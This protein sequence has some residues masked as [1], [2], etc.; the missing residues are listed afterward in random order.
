[1]RQGPEVFNNPGAQ[2]EP[3]KPTPVIN[4]VA[5]AAPEI[6]FQ[7]GHENTR[8]THAHLINERMPGMTI[9]NLDWDHTVT[10]KPP[11]R[12]SFSMELDVA[13]YLDGNGESVELENIDLILIGALQSGRI[14]NI[15]TGKG[16]NAEV[17]AHYLQTRTHELIDKLALTNKFAD[18]RPKTPDG[19]PVIITFT[20]GNGG[21]G[22]D[23][24]SGK[25][26]IHKPI[27]LHS[28]E[29]LLPWS[30][31]LRASTHH[32]R[33]EQIQHKE[34]LIDDGVTVTHPILPPRI[35]YDPMKDEYVLAILHG[36]QVPNTNQ[37]HDHKNDGPITTEEQLYREV[38]PELT[39]LE[40]YHRMHI[41][42]ELRDIMVHVP[43]IATK[44]NL[45]LDEEKI[46]ND[47]QLN[48]WWTKSVE[49]VIYKHTGKHVTITIHDDKSLFEACK[50]LAKYEWRVSIARAKA[51]GITFLDLTAINK[52]L[53]NRLAKNYAQGLYRLYGVPLKKLYTLSHGDNPGK[54]DEDRDES[55][56]DAPMLQAPG[57][58]TNYRG[59]DRPRNDLL[60]PV[61]LDEIYGDFGGL[62]LS[63]KYFRDLIVTA[64]PRDKRAA[65]NIW[66]NGLLY[67]L[68][69]ERKA[70][71]A[72]NTV[73][74]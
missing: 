74:D 28:W 60:W 49:A 64:A 2:Q 34:T 61:Y 13:S 44:G 62:D 1:M 12:K 35:P 32:T 24:I 47:P 46:I 66:L 53:G 33:L 67:E 69:E 73:R 25:V 56:N 17:W 8:E 70:I 5:F 9:V 21:Y 63:N 42:A 45:V 15:T 57:A 36:E 38:E 71:Y 65:E 30:Q 51:Q 23:L 52:R 40:S 4:S 16:A 37:S 7:V 19:K 58:T 14:V 55:T 6:V 72:P 18:G 27:Q 50:I 48:M 54:P 3:N 31:L 10:D 26:F 43:A 29:G 68:R 59:S 22:R 20:S 39:S 41:Q 11:I